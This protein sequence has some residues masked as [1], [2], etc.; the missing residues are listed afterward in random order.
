MRKLRALVQRFGGLFN[1]QRKD[2]ELDEEIESHLHMHIEDN[3]R[4]GMTPEEARRQA[5]IKLGGVESSKEAYR[6]QR[7]LPV[8]ETLWQDIRCG[9]RMLRK[10]PGFTAVAVLTLA[11]GIGA[12]TAIF[13]MVNELFLRPMRVKDAKELLGI[14]LVDRSGDPATQGIPY[15]IYRDY[16]EQNRVF[17]ELLAYAMVSSPMQI[18]E[19]SRLLSVQLASANYFATLGVVPAKG[20]TLFAEDDQSPGQSPVAVI[21]HAFWQSQFQADPEVVGRTFVL[22]PSYV[23][24]LTCTIVGVATAGFTGLDEL[25][26]DIWLPAVMEEHFRRAMSVRFRMVGRLAPNISG[27]QATM[28]LDILTRNIAEKYGGVPLPKY[29]HEGIFRSDSRTELR[30]AALGS[31][32][33]FKPRVVVKRATI[34]ALAVVGLVLLI[35]CANVSNLLLAR[36]IKRRKEIAIRLSLGARRWQL[37]RQMLTESMLLSLLGG[38]AGIFLAHL[39]NQALFAFKPANLDLVVQTAVDHRVVA[40]T[41]VLSILAGLTFGTMPAWQ[42]TACDL[43]SVLKN[44]TSLFSNYRRFQLRD[45]L[46]AAQIALCL[47]LLIG[48]G[49]CGRSFAGLLAVN[50][51]FN[52]GD[53]IVVPLQ[54]KNHTKDTVGPFYLELAQRLTALPGIRSASYTDSFP[55]LGGGETSIPVAQIEGYTPQKDEFIIV[56]YAEVGPNYFETLGIPISQAPDRVLQ[57]RGR[58]VWINE[59]FARR[60]W[61]GQAPVGKSVGPYVINGVVKDSQIRNLTEKP[62]PYLYA[63]DTQPQDTSLVLLVR[64]SGDAHTMMRAVRQEILRGNRDFD[65]TRMQTMHQVLARSLR[66]QQF[67]VA[68]LGGLALTAT[69]LAALGIYGVMSYTVSQRTQEI[70]IRMALGAQRSNM[71]ALVL[72]HGM[73]LSMVGTVFGLLA[74]VATTRVLASV[75]HGISPTDLPTFMSIALLLGIVALIACWLPARRAAK[76]DPMVALR[77]E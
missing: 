60:Y 9:A 22:R 45:V 14:V 62:G 66:H 67:L 52:T 35:A 64:T 8:L 24:P 56:E 15:P 50:P 38:M 13:G 43:N 1:R 69:I 12:N 16:Q 72:K 6:D 39:I 75:L 5:L 44:E 30:H 7:G 61:P 2:R 32:G 76:V 55:M 63:Q 37:L 3:L 26:A 29:E 25:P 34:L 10:N 51:G 21:S 4:L 18:G 19:N 36:A 65:L 31:W 40:F 33:A 70:G 73:L 58:L 59:S 11:L 27:E 42:A 53:I 41:L 71:V 17:S 68:L 74:A 28:G 49:L 57:Q 48:A 46:V 23:Q 47:L 54:V 20:R 77:Y